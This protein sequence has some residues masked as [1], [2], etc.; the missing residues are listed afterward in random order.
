[1]SNAA[2][3]LSIPLNF[4]DTWY[5]GAGTHYKLNDRWTLKTGFRYDSSA[6]KDKDRT[7]FL[8][9]DRV[10]TLGVGGVYDYSET[11][12]IGFTFSWANLGSA[13]VNTASVKGKYTRNE[14]FL[15]GMSFN[16][17]KLPWSG[18]GTL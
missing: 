13:P 17:K 12:E 8:P 1:V 3:T 2:A 15:F 11:M 18:R 5:I 10:W 16:W 6:L 14:L 7:V 4:R 9:V